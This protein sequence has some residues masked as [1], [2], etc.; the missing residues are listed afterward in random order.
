MKLDK[1]DDAL[2][3]VQALLESQV[4]DR[5]KAGII[6]PEYVK[7]RYDETKTKGGLNVDPLELK[8][9]KKKYDTKYWKELPEDVVKHIHRG[10]EDYADT[11]QRKND[12]ATTFAGQKERLDKIKGREKAWKEQYKSIK[13]SNKSLNKNDRQPLPEAP[14]RGLGDHRNISIGI[15]GPVVDFIDYIKSKG[16]KGGGMTADALSTPGFNFPGHTFHKKLPSV[17]VTPSY[18]FVKSDTYKN[19]LDKAKSV[20]SK[21]PKFTSIINKA[22][23][24]FNKKYITWLQ[25]VDHEVG[26]SKSAKSNINLYAHGEQ[27]GQHKVD[28]LSHEGE[29]TRQLKALS[30][31]GNSDFLD[32]YRNLS[33]EKGWIKSMR[34]EA[35]KEYRKKHG[36]GEN[37]PITGKHVKNIRDHTIN[38]IRSVAK[39]HP[40]KDYNELEHLKQM[41]VDKIKGEPVKWAEVVGG[42]AGIYGVNKLQGRPA[43]IDISKYST[44]P[45]NDNMFDKAESGVKQ[46][47]GD[48]ALDKV[49]KMS[50]Y[51]KN[52]KNKMVQNVSNKKRK[53]GKGIDEFLGGIKNTVIKRKAI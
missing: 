13:K 6:D 8:A 45:G 38:Y 50:D 35:H 20:A 29:T 5:L 40:K 43:K 41:A 15:P 47:A 17:I 42:T 53:I 46:I 3:K 4:K 37:E 51:V 22:E 34:D 23:A 44:A 18:R 19:L 7:K 11:L 27:V 30:K 2:K 16:W 31:H 33:G 21:N 48:Y 39:Q 52:K 1:Y 28:A 25:T 9:A 26:E 14:K 24:F 32:K 10:T 36:I 12:I 49:N